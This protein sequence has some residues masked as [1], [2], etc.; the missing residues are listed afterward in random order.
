MKKETEL[1]NAVEKIQCTKIDN[2]GEAMYIWAMKNF[3]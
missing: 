2:C 1:L 3:S